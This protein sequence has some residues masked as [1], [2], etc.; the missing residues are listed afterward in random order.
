[1]E[2]EREEEDSVKQE[3]IMNQS[4][5]IQLRLWWVDYYYYTVSKDVTTIRD[6]LIC[7][8]VPKAGRTGQRQWYRFR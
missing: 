6:L 5:L 4:L 7:S 2:R 3:L 8:I 1:M